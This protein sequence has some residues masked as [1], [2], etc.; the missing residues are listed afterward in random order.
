M[1]RTDLPSIV[2]GVVA[3]GPFRRSLVPY[4][5]YSAHYYEHTQ[6]DARIIVTLLFDFHDP[7][8]LRDAGECLGLDP[9][10]FNTHVIDPARI[11]LEG[12][13]II[14][15]DDGLPERITALKDAGYQFYFRMKHRDVL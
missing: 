2:A 3:I 6:E 12:L 1:A 13:G 10:D 14:W 15:D 4:L 9:W 5:E 7:V 8:L 11:D